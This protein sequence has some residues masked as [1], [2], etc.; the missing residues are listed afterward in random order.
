MTVM[1]GIHAAFSNSLLMSYV[2]LLLM[3]PAAP[4][5]TYNSTMADENKNTKKV[6]KSVTG[7]TF[8]KDE[9]KQHK[10]LLALGCL[11]TA[12]GAALTGWAGDKV[13][14]CESRGTGAYRHTLYSVHVG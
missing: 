13:R 11:L 9:N 7:K 10:L 3:L 6:V 12:G 14:T 4:S 1:C 2:C 5:F 8:T